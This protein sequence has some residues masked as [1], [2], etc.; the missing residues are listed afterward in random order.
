MATDLIGFIKENIMFVFIIGMLCS[1]TIFYVSKN[2]SYIPE[3]EYAKITQ[4]EAD[5]NEYNL[6]IEGSGLKFENL[7]KGADPEKSQSGVSK[8]TVA[9]AF[10]VIGK[11]FEGVKKSYTL[12]NYIFGSNAMIVMSV[13]I[14]LS[15]FVG[16]LLG[17]RNIFGKY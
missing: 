2:N 15:M 10:S 7:S 13:F 5:I 17:L 16:V 11:G 14:G 12:A 4:T 9:G 6:N 3:D 1:F 8:E